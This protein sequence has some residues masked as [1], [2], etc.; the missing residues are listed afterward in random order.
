[1]LYGIPIVSLHIE[2]QERL[3]L[4]Q[5][6]NTLLKTFSYNEIHNR[7][8]ALGITCVQCTPVQ[9]EI[10][11]RAGA[12]PVSSRRCGMITRREAERLC[13]SFLG[14]NSPPRLPDDFSFSV[15]HEC[16][17][18]CRGQF[19][20]SRYNS[21]RAKCIKC[22]YCG[23]FFSPNKFIFHSHR[24]GPNDKYIQPDA[25]N[26]NS[27]RR[28]MKLSG[29]S[30]DDIVHAWE[31]VKAMF[32][33]GTRKRLMHSSSVS[34]RIRSS[35]VSNASPTHSEASPINPGSSDMIGMLQQSPLTDNQSPKRMKETNSSSNPSR[36]PIMQAVA[37]VAAAAAAKTQPFPIRPVNINPSKIN[38]GCSN[39]LSASSLCGLPNRI[40]TSTSSEILPSLQFSRSFMMD[41]MWHAQQQH[42]QQQHLQHQNQK[43]SP[44]FHFPAYALPWLKRPAATILFNHQNFRPGQP[45]NLNPP[46]NVED[47]DGKNPLGKLGASEEIT[48][49]SKASYN[50][51]A[52][53]YCKSSAFKPVNAVQRCKP[54]GVVNESTAMPVINEELSLAS[55]TNRINSMLNRI[56]D[57]VSISLKVNENDRSKSRLRCYNRRM[58][59]IFSKILINNATSK[60]DEDPLSS[61][62]EMVDIESTEEQLSIVAHSNNGSRNCKARKSN[63]DPFETR[64]INEVRDAVHEGDNSD[65]IVIVKN[66]G[67]SN[68]N[69]TNKSHSSGSRN[70]N[71]SQSIKDRDQANGLS[72]ND[73]NNNYQNSSNEDDSDQN[74]DDQSNNSDDDIQNSEINVETNTNDNSV[75]RSEIININANSDI[76]KNNSVSTE[77]K[78]FIESGS[79]PISLNENHCETVKNKQN[80]ND[81]PEYHNEISRNNAEYVAKVKDTEENSKSEMK[82]RERGE[83]NAIEE[84]CY[85]DHS[86]G[87][88]KCNENNTKANNDK[89]NTN[90]S[91]D[92]KDNRKINQNNNSNNSNS[93]NVDNKNNSNK[94]NNRSDKVNETRVTAVSYVDN[95]GKL[96]TNRDYNSLIEQC[97]STKSNY[98]NAE[99]TLSDRKKPSNGTK[100]GPNQMTENSTDS[101]IQL[102]LKKEVRFMYSCFLCFLSSY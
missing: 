72:N 69:N 3:C 96:S 10:L 62:E 82:E 92:N 1:M 38:G 80:V 30:P 13:K 86:N 9:L 24:L 102:T 81:L 50:L 20:P 68:R 32:N 6:S 29:V 21:S 89:I 31:D 28:H 45:T 87:S 70:R 77:D 52:L 74:S 18:G 22:S 15:F 93:K 60:A 34:S 66:N 11:R 59:N 97:N 53:Q 63:T 73:Q 39:M 42:H 54:T 67:S 14:D 19:L 17:W 36:Q 55:T 71:L 78:E 56:N 58:S 26:F 25:A 95:I 76:R 2:A 33:G 65:L 16:A 75:S 4:A 48:I 47:A 64:S 51:A 84:N 88:I 12:M 5:I 49:N 98:N 85:N 35:S 83:I 7:R 101:R 57:P 43:P 99:I 91:N 100:D 94:R 27:W 79:D 61:D 40:A 41:Y 46:G 90:N 37:A 23:L 8:V 44:N